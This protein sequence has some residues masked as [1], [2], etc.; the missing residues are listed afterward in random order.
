MDTLLSLEPVTSQYN[1]KGMR[2]LYDVVE[3]QVRSL[4]SL[5]VS[6]ESYG[7]LLTLVLMNKLR[8]SRAK[9]NSKQTD[10]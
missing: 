5:G 3:S 2:H 9:I 8:T 7:G 1:L 6:A 10:W 4:R